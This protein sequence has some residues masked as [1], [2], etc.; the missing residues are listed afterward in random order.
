[1]DPDLAS[2][3][4]VKQSEMNQWQEKQRKL[5]A[6]KDATTRRVNAKLEEYKKGY[7]EQFATS[8][9]LKEQDYRDLEQR[10]EDLKLQKDLQER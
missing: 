4:L 2:I 10:Y 6:E 3:V 8:E 9:R 5:K 7:A 1:M